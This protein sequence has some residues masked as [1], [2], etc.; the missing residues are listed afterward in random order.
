VLVEGVEPA[1]EKILRRLNRYELS[2][3]PAF[4]R[5]IV[6]LKY[7]RRGSKWAWSAEALVPSDP[8]NDLKG[9]R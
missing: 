8:R 7:L 4:W 9:W 2:F 3:A 1:L 6:A 5:S